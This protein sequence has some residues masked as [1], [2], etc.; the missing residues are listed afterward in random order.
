MVNEANKAHNTIKFTLEV[1]GKTLNFLDVHLEIVEGQV[2]TSLYRKET[3]RNNVLHANSFHAPNII[4]AIPRGQFLRARRISSNTGSL[5]SAT[6]TLRG[7]FLDR[8]YNR[9]QI[10]NCIQETNKVDRKDLLMYKTKKEE[11]KSL[12]FVST[13]GSHSKAIEKIVLKYWPIIQQDRTIGKCYPNNPMFS[14]KRGECIRDIL[15]PS[16]ID[17][18]K[19]ST[20][21]FLGKP[22]KGT[23]ACLNCVCCASII[24]GDRV[25][26]PLYGTPLFLKNYATCDTCNVVYLLKCPCGMAYVGQTARQIKIRIKE[27]RG[28][29]RNYKKDT[30]TD[31]AVARHFAEMKHNVNQLKWLV[32]EVVQNPPRGGDVKTKLLQREMYWIKKLNTMNPKG[33][34]ESW[35]VKSFL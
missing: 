3:D 5:I 8:G 10:H 12:P 2:C 27:H 14:Y 29:I 31:T 25:N 34:N 4:K 28:Y 19:S 16:E 1:G 18:P 20:Q 13:Y 32:L 22:K 30:Y 21:R 11:K 23:F 33:L 6:E 15:C 7:R 9:K 24:K 17:P 26:H 35:S